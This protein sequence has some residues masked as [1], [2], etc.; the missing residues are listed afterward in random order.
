MERILI[1]N[2]KTLLSAAQGLFKLSSDAFLFSFICSA[3]QSTKIHCP[4]CHWDGA[5]RLGTAWWLTLRDLRLGGLGWNDG[6][7]THNLCVLGQGLLAPVNSRVKG[8]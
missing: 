8:G 4:H 5:E 7:N 2:V 6:S 1:E 3:V